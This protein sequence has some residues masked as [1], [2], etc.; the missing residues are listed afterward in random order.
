MSEQKTGPRAKDDRSNIE[1][2]GYGYGDRVVINDC[3]TKVNGLVESIHREGKKLDVRI[4]H[5]GHKNHNRVVTVDQADADIHPA[6]QN[7]NE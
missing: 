6:W 4:D 1:G 3:N 5:P 2:S 7:S